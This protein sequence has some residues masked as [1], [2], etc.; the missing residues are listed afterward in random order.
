MFAWSPYAGIRSPGVASELAAKLSTSPQPL[1]AFLESLLG[2]EVTVRVLAGPD[3]RP[4]TLT[5]QDRLAAGGI[6]ACRHRSSLLYAG[7][8]VA[9]SATLVWLPARLPEEAC[10]ALDAGLVPA[11]KI[12]APYGMRRVDCRAMDTTGIEEVTGGNAAVQSTAVLAI[13]GGRRVAIA[14]EF[15]LSTFAEQLASAMSS[16]ARHRRRADRRAVRH[17]H[18]LHAV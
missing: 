15:I 16:L 9:A 6:A 14:E 1:T 13:L 2:T 12:L 8:T 10:R 18:R 7:G 17:R 5:E 11:G 3:D 4:V